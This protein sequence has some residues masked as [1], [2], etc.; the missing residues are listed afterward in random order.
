MKI[1]NIFLLAIS[2]IIS[3]MS[4]ADKYDQ[5]VND[6]MALVSD[7]SKLEEHHDKGLAEA[8]ADGYTTFVAL[9]ETKFVKKGAAVKNLY[10]GQLLSCG[11]KRYEIYEYS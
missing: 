11:V 3:P 8:E 9:K 1:L 6:L 10:D 4:Y 2:L 5:L 7:S